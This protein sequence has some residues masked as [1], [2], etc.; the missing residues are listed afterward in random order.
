MLLAVASPVAYTGMSSFNLVRT[1]IGSEGTITQ[2]ER[3]TFV[4][5]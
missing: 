5:R 3:I 4:R 1:I 2:I